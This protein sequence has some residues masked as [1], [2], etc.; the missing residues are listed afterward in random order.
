[1][2]TI[3]GTGTG[4]SDA[5]TGGCTGAAADG[6]SAAAHARPGVSA[7]VSTV[8]RRK[9]VASYKENSAGTEQEGDDQV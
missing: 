9:G 1:M 8:S 2:G 6:S 5:W 7:R 4:G 3:T